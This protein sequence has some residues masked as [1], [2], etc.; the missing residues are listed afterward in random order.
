M[1]R[2][3]L[4]VVA[5]IAI[6]AFVHRGIAGREALLAT[7]RTVILATAPVDPRAVMQGDYMRLTWQVERD[8]F[9]RRAMSDVP[10]DGRV[11]VALDARGVGT[12]S[13]LDDGSALAPGEV[14]LRYRVREGGLHFA[15]NAWFFQE[16]KGAAYA[17]AK[18][19]EFRVADDGEM[20][21]VA[22]RDAKLDLL[23]APMEGVKVAPAPG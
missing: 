11:V 6:L 15:T 3:V 7:G 16:G 1:I 13:R 23:G 21:L 8:A 12:F 9:P 10:H 20:I 22:L 2:R 5:T 4:L 19:G 14:A 17:G 18:F